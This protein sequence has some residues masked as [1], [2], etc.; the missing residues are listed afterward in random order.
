MT[1][2]FFVIIPYLSTTLG[3]GI[4]GGKKGKEKEKEGAELFETSRSQLEQ[5]VEVVQQGLVSCG[6]RVAQLE[7]EALIELYY[8]LFNPGT[9]EKRIG[10]TQK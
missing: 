9:T 6:I 2:N 4:I 10:D 7:T 5:R 8:Q 1:K 3:K